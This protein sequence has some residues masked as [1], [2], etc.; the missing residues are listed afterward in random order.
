MSRSSS[1]AEW[2]SRSR[3]RTASSS[4]RRDVATNDHKPEMSAR[5]VTERLIR[6]LGGGDYAFVLM[7]YANPD[8]V[9]HSGIVPA[10]ARRSR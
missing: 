5:E 9:G 1:T 10:A 4:L 7:N 8:M 6:Q 3:A 2:R